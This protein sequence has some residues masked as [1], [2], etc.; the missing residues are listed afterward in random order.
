MTTDTITAR[1]YAGDA[2]LEPAAAFLNFVEAHDQVDE[3]TSAEEMR[4]EFAEPGF[5]PARDIRIVEDEA[6]AIIGFG[7]IWAVDESAENDGFLW[8]KVHPERRDGSV[9][10]LLFAWAEARLRELGRVKLA[11][12]AR[13]TETERQ[14]LIERHGFAPVR[15]FLRMTRPLSEPIPEPQLPDGYTLRAESHDPQ[16][17]ADMYNESFVDH[18]NFHRHTA[19]QIRHWQSEPDYRPELNLAAVAPDGTLAAFAWCSVNPEENARTGRSEGWVG[20]LGTRRGHRQIGLGRAML[21]HALRALRDAGVAHAKLGVDATS[22]TGA[23]RLYES[24]G[25]TTSF[26]R[27]LYSRDLR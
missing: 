2:D 11:V 13:E 23:N 5:D 4:V 26:S 16:A 25:F 14:A 8:F 18:Y 19:E 9:E 17:W 1:P 7:Q 10:P 12:H 20:V 21:L 27:T 24:A 6:G 15:Y 22:P 3:S